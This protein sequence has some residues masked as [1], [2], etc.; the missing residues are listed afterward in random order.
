MYVDFTDIN[1]ACPKDNFPLP[2]IDLLVDFIAGHELLSFMDAYSGYNQI[3]MSPKNKEHTSFMTNQGTYCYKVMPFGLKNAGATF[4]RLVNKM[5]EK[6]ICRN[7]EVYV[8]DMLVKS[9]VTGDHI[10]DLEESFE[11]LRKH[12]MK[13][14]PTKCVFGVASGK[15]LGFIVSQWGIEAN[16]EKIKALQHGNRPR[17]WTAE[18]QAAFDELKR[19]LAIPPLL[20]SPK[21]GEELY[22][23]LA[24]SEASLSSILVRQDS[25]AQRPVNYKPDVSGRLVKWAIE[26]GE[27]DMEFQPRPAV[28]A[29]ALADFIVE[30]TTPVLEEQ[31]EEKVNCLSRV[32]EWILHINGS[33]LDTGRCVELSLTTPGGFEV[34]YSLGLDSGNQQ[35]ESTKPY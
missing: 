26:L 1:K 30:T 18:C 7:M 14:N 32:L 9:K 19:Y 11:V 20:V 2:R 29:Q 28:K 35:F 10:R 21:G 23:Y 15:F 25:D 34:K 17:N 6:Y 31:P 4:Q 27:F 3:R 33:R 16:P 22:L 13:L 24:V 5:F 12:H 8:D